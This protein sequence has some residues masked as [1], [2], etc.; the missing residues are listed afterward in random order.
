MKKFHIPQEDQ[1]TQIQLSL[2]DYKNEND[3][4]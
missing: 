3:L 1:H 4:V 2:T